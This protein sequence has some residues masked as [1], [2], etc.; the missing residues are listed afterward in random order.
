[1]P[2]KKPETPAAPSLADLADPERAASLYRKGPP[3]SIAVALETIPEDQAD[4]LRKALENEN[5]RGIDIADALLPYG[6]DVGAHTV[7]RHRRGRC[8]CDR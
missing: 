3:C 8:R 4:L 2:A 1:M 6:I 7:Q 5:A